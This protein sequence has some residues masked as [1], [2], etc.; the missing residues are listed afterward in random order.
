MRRATL[1]SI[2]I[3]GSV[4]AASSPVAAHVSVANTAL[5]IV[6]PGR[7]TVDVGDT[8]T[9]SGKLRGHPRCRAGQE[10]E[11]LEAGT[12]VDTT[13]TDVDGHYTFTFV[14][15]GPTALQTQFDG[16]SSGVHPHLHLCA[17]STS[18]VIRIR[19][20]SGASATTGSMLRTL[21]GV[22]A[23]VGDSIVSRVSAT[24]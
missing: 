12:T 2:L 7:R 8:I 21:D 13:V 15:T 11:L 6:G 4:I 23:D 19:T 17:A 3:V 20:G 24:V 14:V 9:I 22:L 10:I 16:S 1:I 5:T 18:R